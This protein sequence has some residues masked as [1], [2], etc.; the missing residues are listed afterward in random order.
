MD[1]ELQQYVE[2]YLKEALPDGMKNM[3]TGIAMNASGAREWKESTVSTIL[4]E[5]R[6]VTTC[7]YVT[8]FGPFLNKKIS[9][10]FLAQHP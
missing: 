6:A 3:A 8:A 4:S 1:V 9:R 5:R 7:S 10:C 2:A